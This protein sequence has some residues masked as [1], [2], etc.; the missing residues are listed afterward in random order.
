MHITNEENQRSLK[1]TGIKT[2]KYNN[3]VYFMPVLN[4]YLISHQWARELK[5]SG[6]RNYIAVYFK[7]DSDEK[8]WFGKYSEEHKKMPL[9]SAIKLFLDQEDKLGYEFFIERKIEVKEITKIRHIP[10]P[11]GWRYE[12][13]AHGK[14]PCPC[15]VCIQRGGFKTNKLRE[16]DSHSISRLEAKEIIAKSNDDDDIWLALLRLSGK[17]RKESP[18]YLKRLLEFSD[19]Y[20]LEA[21]VGLLAEFRHPLA[22]EYLSILASSDNE[23][24]KE[25]ATEY[26]SKE[27]K[28][29]KIN[30][31]V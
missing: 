19:D 15:P 31:I 28:A 16:D 9:N 17:R 7:L 5:R 25:L 3:I 23:D 26:L 4:D 14:E 6:V 8:I 11:M 30:I 20:L 10:K 1:N 18:E 22:K 29:E 12:P 24:I 2:G 13:H 21:L 27:Y